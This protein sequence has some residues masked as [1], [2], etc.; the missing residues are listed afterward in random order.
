MN[1]KIPPE[2]F[3]FY[4]GLGAGRS[5]SAVAKEFDV[6]KRAITSCA[7]REGWATRLETVERKARERADERMVESIDEMGERHLRI[8]RVVQ[9][10]ALEAIKDMPIATAMD[11]ARALDMTIKQERLIRGEPTDR[12]TISLEEVVRKEHE[13]WMANDEEG[14][15]DGEIED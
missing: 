11:A 2:A 12:S 13:R 9:T 6:S 14:E 10:R 4:C 15:P 8:V 7:K 1:R 5:Y 3:E